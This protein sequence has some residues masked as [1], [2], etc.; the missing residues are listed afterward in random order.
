MYRL[1]V[2][3]H[4]LQ[5]VRSITQAVLTDMYE[6]VLVIALIQQMAQ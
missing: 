4:V 3:R 2:L 6:Y 5:L 1:P